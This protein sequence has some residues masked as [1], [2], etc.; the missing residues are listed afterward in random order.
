[1]S[2]NKNQLCFDIMEMIGKEYETIK[3]RN[4][5]LKD[6]TYEIDTIFLKDCFGNYKVFKRQI[7]IIKQDQ[8]SYMEC[9]KSHLKLKPYL[10]KDWKQFYIDM[11]DDFSDDE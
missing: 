6:L 2:L 7:K 8:K 10:Q 11:I 9:W 1:M 4:K 5:I 3:Y